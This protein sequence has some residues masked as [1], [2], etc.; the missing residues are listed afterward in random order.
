MMQEAICTVGGPGVPGRELASAGTS[1]T[2]R[3]E[4]YF[5]RPLQ[6]SEAQAAIGTTVDAITCP[7]KFN[8]EKGKFNPTT[9]SYYPTAQ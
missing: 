2:R 4:L 6:A 9:P 3:Q 8:S 1:P 5:C 7:T